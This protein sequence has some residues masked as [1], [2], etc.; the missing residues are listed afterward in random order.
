MKKLFFVYIALFLTANVFGQAPEK[1]SYQAVIRDVDNQLVSNQAIGM[2]I[3]ILQGS[4]D[5]AEVY[6]ETYN[7]NPTTNVNGLVSLEIG[8]GVPLAGNFSTI[9]WANGSYFIK[10]E[11]DLKGGTDYNISGTSQLVSVPYALYAENG[12]K[13]GSVIGEM[14]F[15]NGVNWESVIPGQDGDILTLKNGIPTWRLFDEGVI[16][17]N[18]FSYKEVTNPTTGRTWLDRNLGAT[19]VAINSTDSNAYG[20]LYQ[21][22]RGNDG[23]QIRTS[24]TTATLSTS[25]TP[26]HGKFI[27]NSDYPDDWRS[28]RNDNL[29]QGVDG[30]NNPC[31][32]GFRVPTIEE[33]ELE[34]ESW[35]SKNASGAF[36][37]PLKLPLSG[38][39]IG[40]NGKLYNIDN[41]ADYWSSS[42]NDTNSRGLVF[43][44]NSASIY[45]NNRSYGH[46]IRCIKD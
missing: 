35:S 29:W 46:S 41:A 30:I 18:G 9:D 5:G 43:S 23:H 24:D 2:R 33:W 28:P 3:S 45:S 36:G 6:Q 19:Q 17:H 13:D 34:R 31:P 4:A 26:G 11:T 10:I 44:N 16:V 39:R 37:S 21:W 40:G 38:S 25:D 8:T 32:N 1:M 20:D 14:L 12:V 7:P 22:G 27:A 15:W 42:I